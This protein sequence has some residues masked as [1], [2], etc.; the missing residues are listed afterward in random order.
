MLDAWGLQVLVTVARRGSFSG[1]AEELT[2]TQPAVS[3]QIAA[4]ERRLGVALF[5]RAAR[6]VHP[7]PA[8]EAAVELARGVLARMEALEATMRTFAGLEGAQLR[9]AGFSSVNTHFVP[10]AIRRFAAAHPSVTVSLV[11]VDP[12]AALDAVRDGRVEVALVTEWQLSSDPW[13]A[14]TGDRMPEIDTDGV[15]VT[16]LVDEELRVA[17][18]TAH[19]LAR[20]PRVALAQLREERWIDG[21]YPDCL[22]PLR[23]LADALGAPP[24]IG[25]VC[26]D[27]NGKQALVAGGA[28]IMVVPTLARTAIRNDLVVRPTTPEL[29]RRRLFAATALPPFRTPAAEAMVTVLR[30]T[31]DAVAAP[32]SGG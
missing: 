18:P 19:R 7:T 1:A 8:G 27:W 17:L 28:G 24:T 32:V 30:R 23:P 26:D 5:R 21:A 4:L 31:S 2:L 14:R 16:L 6:G 10:D 29:P 13:A 20:S 12:L 22:G 9:I 15:D 25:F 3:R 11:Q